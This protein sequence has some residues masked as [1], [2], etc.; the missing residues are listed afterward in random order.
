MWPALGRIMSRHSD[1]DKNSS[2]N[3]KDFEPFKVD[4]HKF[5]HCYGQ[6]TYKSQ[7]IKPSGPDNYNKQTKK[8]PVFVKFSVNKK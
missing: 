5:I 3:A 8:W 2:Q 6:T 1:F 4:F 7:K